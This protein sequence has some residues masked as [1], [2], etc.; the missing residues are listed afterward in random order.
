MIIDFSICAVYNDIVSLQNEK[1]KGDSMT[2][3][4][5]T[6]IKE[7]RQNKKVTQ[8]ELAQYL[9]VT[10]QAIS[11]WESENGY[12]DIEFLPAI[13]AFFSITID[14]L[15]GVN[16]T[17]REARRAEIEKYMR[18]IYDGEVTIDDVQI[19]NAR[20]FVAEFPSDENVRKFLAD[21]LYMYYRFFGE[22]DKKCLEEAEKIYISLIETT[23]D[24]DF[25]SETLKTLCILYSLG[26][27]DRRRAMLM[28]EKLP[29]MINSR[30]FACASSVSCLEQEPG[31]TTDDDAKFYQQ[32]L[33]DILT[34]AL[35]NWLVNY[36]INRIPNGRERFDEKVDMFY[37][38]I[39]LYKFIYGENLLCHH[40]D[41]AYI[42]RVIATYRVAQKRYDE[43]LDVLEKMCY[44]CEKRVETQ[45]GDNFDSEFSY[46]LKS[47]GDNTE[48]QDDPIHN[49]AWFCL[50]RLDQSRYDPLREMPKFKEIVDR[51]KAIAK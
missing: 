36:I 21:T 22:K 12:P 25:K 14:E 49:I 5:G 16:L 8:D 43:T 13:A 41:V 47:Y 46:L 32:K 24:V 45:I 9:G 39:D 44:H 7:L 38:V 50:I 31:S 6:K 33:I 18:E 20:Q 27:G 51:L 35:G 34:D 26:Y 37:K 23:N 2:I 29:S 30:E 48:Y 19:E 10:P 4:I 3:K 17:E 1:R 15:L 28:A 42:Y 40:T 11:R